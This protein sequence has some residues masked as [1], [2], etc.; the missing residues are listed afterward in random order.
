MK[1]VPVVPNNSSEVEPF[2]LTIAGPMLPLAVLLMK[3]PKIGLLPAEAFPVRLYPKT[4]VI[5]AWI[6]S[7]LGSVAE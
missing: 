5:G 4:S 3:R 2:W 1:A 6:W 7:D